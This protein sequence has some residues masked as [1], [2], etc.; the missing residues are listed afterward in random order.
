MRAIF[1]HWPTLFILDRSE[2]QEGADRK[3]D[4]KN[5]G[6]RVEKKEMGMRERGCTREY[7]LG[8]P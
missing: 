8:L 5:G 2:H 7:P 1:F 3:D 6:E 4:G